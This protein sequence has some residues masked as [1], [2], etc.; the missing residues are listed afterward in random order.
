MADY[1]EFLKKWSRVNQITSFFGSDKPD[2]IRDWN[3]AKRGTKFEITRGKF[4]PVETRPVAELNAEL[5]NSRMESE[6]LKKAIEEKLP[7]KKPRRESERIKNRKLQK[8]SQ[9]VFTY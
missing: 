7:V 1:N 9:V 2:F 5:R 8:S 4:I 6:M 3:L